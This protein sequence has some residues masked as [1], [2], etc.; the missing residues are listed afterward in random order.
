MTSSFTIDQ[1]SWHT[2]APGNIESR[3]HIARRFAAVANFLQDSGLTVRNLSCP[4]EEIGNDF[5]IN[6]EDLTEEGLAVI[7][8]SY[9]KWLT[10]VDNGMPPEDV[11]LL[12]NTLRS[13]SSKSIKERNNRTDK[14]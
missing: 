2:N 5:A 1:V 9:N 7:K 8:A 10:K 3:E 4:E 6:S 11:S 12:E 13:I 14:F